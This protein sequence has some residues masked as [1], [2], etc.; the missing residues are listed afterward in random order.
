MK[1]IIDFNQNKEQIAKWKAVA[2][3]DVDYH[4]RQFERPYRSTVQ[5]GEFIQ[6]LIGSARGEALDVGCGAGANIYHLDES[7]PGFRWTGL[8]I[9]GNV[10]FDIAKPFFRTE[11]LDVALLEGDFASLTDRFGAK[12]FDLVLSLQTMLVLPSYERLLDQMLSVTKGWLFI[13]SLFTDFQ[14]DVNIEVKNFTWSEG[15]RD[16]GHYNVYSLSR[17]RAICESRG[18]KEFISRDF[19]I[20]VDLPVPENGGFGTY[21]RTLQDGKRLQFTG[22]IFQP[23]KFIGIRMGDSPPASPPGYP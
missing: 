12:K 21:T 18:C 13:S 7:I 1:G 8:D 16:P 2:R 19:D 5:M 17:F 6:S 23:W 3:Q 10:V 9:A 4:R 15:C 14:V 20:D 22:P 11:K